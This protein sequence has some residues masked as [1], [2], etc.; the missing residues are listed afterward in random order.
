MKLS[1][2][3]KGDTRWNITGEIESRVK[4]NFGYYDVKKCFSMPTTFYV[5]S[6]KC[7]HVKKTWKDWI[8]L[9]LSQW[10]E[11]QS[12]DEKLEK[13]RSQAAKLDRLPVNIK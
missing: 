8:N 10:I 13:N 7:T 12:Q 9:K 3:M 1:I 6:L 11:N 2:R 5:C 4:Q